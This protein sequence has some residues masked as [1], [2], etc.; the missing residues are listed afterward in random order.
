[1][2]SRGRPVIP[3][4]ASYPQRPLR[5]EANGVDIYNSDRFPRVPQDQSGREQWQIG[6]DSPLMRLRAPPALWRARRGSNVATASAGQQF[7]HDSY[8]TYFSRGKTGN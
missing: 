4:T 1:M 3:A 2:F 6:A 7:V 5:I 8:P